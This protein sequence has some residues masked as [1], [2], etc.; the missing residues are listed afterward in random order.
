MLEKYFLR[1]PTPQD[2]QAVFDLQIR[3]DFRDAGFADSDIEDLDYDWG[4]INLARDAW[5]AINGKGELKGYAAVLPW[6]EHGCR[7]VIYDDLC[8]LNPCAT[9]TFRCII[10]YKF[11]Q[12]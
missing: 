6:Y 10:F 7:L 12:T 2:R 1:P 9:L 8:C 11:N 4:R 5:L 3:C